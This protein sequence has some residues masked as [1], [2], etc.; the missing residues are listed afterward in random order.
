M[1]TEHQPKEI[2]PTALEES[3]FMI[4]TS[5]LLRMPLLLVFLD[6]VSDNLWSRNSSCG[7]SC[8]FSELV[9]STDKRPFSCSTTRNTLTCATLESNM[10]LDLQEMRSLES[11]IFCSTEKTSEVNLLII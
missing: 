2:G 8:H 3:M 1:S 9:I 4:A 6:H 11:A 7:L 5:D 10:N